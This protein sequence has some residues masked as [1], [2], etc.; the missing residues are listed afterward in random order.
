MTY[1]IHALCMVLTVSLHKPAAAMPT[2]VEHNSNIR[3]LQR[4]FSQHALS[5]DLILKM[6]FSLLPIQG[7]VTLSMDRTNRKFGGDKRQYPYARHNLQK[8][9]VSIDFQ[10]YAQT[11]RL[12][13]GGTQISC[14]EVY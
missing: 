13:S 7:K 2:G 11:V 12:Q 1:V 6:T 4:F 5:L 14:S 3:R 10:A 8:N 9:S